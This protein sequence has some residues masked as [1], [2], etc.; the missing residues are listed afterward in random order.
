LLEPEPGHPRAN[1]KLR[2]LIILLRE[3]FDPWI[4]MWSGEGQDYAERMAHSVGVHWYIDQYMSKMDATAQDF[5]PDF[6]IDDAQTCTMGK[7]NL[8]L[9]QGKVK[10]DDE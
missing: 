2:Q 3:L 10:G 6:A 8:H 7:I 5:K 9:L 1:E 4:I